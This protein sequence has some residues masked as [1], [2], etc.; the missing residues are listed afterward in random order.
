MRQEREKP[1]PKISFFASKKKEKNWILEYKWRSKKDFEM[2]PKTFSSREYSEDWQKTSWNYKFRTPEGAE[3]H[4][5]AQM[6]SP[7][8]EDTIKGRDW[9]VRSLI[10][11]EII[12][13]PNLDNYYA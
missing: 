6:R 11:L 1:T 5:K 8:L 4:L 9:R 13:I 10:T 7:Y 3:Q 2:Y 12:N